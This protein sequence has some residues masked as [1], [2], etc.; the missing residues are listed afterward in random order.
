MS[1]TT[2]KMLLGLALAAGVA[3][4]GPPLA[5]AEADGFVGFEAVPAQDLD[6]TRGG[7]QAG[8]DLLFSFGIEKAVYVNGVLEATSSMNLL[9]PAGGAGQLSQAPTFKLIQNGSG[10]PNIGKDFSAFSL[11]G[12][13]FQGTII[14]NSLDHQKIQTI[15]KISVGVN[16][17]GAFR[18]NTLSGIVNR[19]LLQSLR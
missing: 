7:Y 19:Q 8:N 12:Q 14:Q 2:R 11:P 6:S 18:E 3:S 1:T 5:R 4:W 10:V 16:A 13:G 15:T 9:Q 17:I